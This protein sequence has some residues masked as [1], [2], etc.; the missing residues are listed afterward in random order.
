M[1]CA[2]LY[3]WCA[4]A[5]LFRGWLRAANF[6]VCHLVRGP[7]CVGCASAQSHDAPRRT[8]DAMSSTWC[9]QQQQQQQQGSV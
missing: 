8:R 7:L 2:L 3:C 1:L 6:M 9:W 5:L 4:V